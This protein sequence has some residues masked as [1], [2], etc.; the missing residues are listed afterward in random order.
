MTS[1]A[2]RFVKDSEFTAFVNTRVNEFLVKNKNHHIP[3]GQD[4]SSFDHQLATEALQ[5]HRFVSK[6]E[7]PSEDESLTRATESVQS[8]L[9]Y[10]SSGLTSFNP[11]ADKS[12]CGFSRHI[13]YNARKTLNEAIANYS[14]S[15]SHLE[16]TSGETYVSAR[17]DT[18][19]YAKLRDAK[20][21]T[22]TRSCFDLASR[23]I[24]NSPMLRH[25]A[26]V[27]YKS[28]F[29]KVFDSLNT[30]LTRKQAWIEWNN[31]LKLKVVG[32]QSGL[33]GKESYHVFREKL[34]KVVTI[35]PGAR[36]TTVP[37]NNSTDRVIECECWLNMLV[38]RTI[39]GSLRKIIKDF[40]G[41]D[42]ERS[43]DLH[44]MLISDL[45]NVTI[46]LKNASNSNWLCVV[47]WM[48]DR[49]L[50]L[51]H[52]K[53]SRC[54]LVSYNDEWNRLNMLSPNGNGYTFEVM[55]L[56]LLCVAR[57]LDSFSFVYGDDIIIDSDV[58]QCYIDVVQKMGYVLN[59]SK[60]F[61]SGS[62]RESCGAFF[63]EG[64]ITSYDLHYAND[65]VDA[66]ILTNKIG[67][68]GKTTDSLLSKQ[69]LMLH[70]ELLDVCPRNLLRGVDFNLINWST[71]K[72]MVPDLA[73][74]ILCTKSYIRSA[75]SKDPV[76]IKEH[77]NLLIDHMD[78]M[79]DLNYKPHQLSFYRYVSKRSKTYA[80][81]Y[82][83]FE[84][85][86][87]VNRTLGWFYV[88]SGRAKAPPLRAT[89]LHSEYR[90]SVT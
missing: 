84:S 57:E 22:V 64:Y 88:W 21:W 10:D 49:T 76:W 39:S 70:R 4:Y 53:Q 77:R 2:I 86:I 15:V 32:H 75:R 60:T 14:F 79:C 78:L 45:S 29:N 46:D 48:L 72:V 51:S 27:H 58:A 33:N 89:Y 11:G 9:K 1:S 30:T 63:C 69:W 81:M 35:V 85:K 82:D 28:Y 25:A 36:L 24:Y 44:G 40:Y 26:K 42:L 31:H 66:I 80:D 19:V 13:I 71:L 20:Q 17:G 38:Q 74:G 23:L 3:L 54:G 5:L 34:R 52:L 18:S 41:V 16:L 62:F 47:E 6:F 37:K 8:M 56:M 67:I 61:L 12:L 59:T 50:L 68:M 87:K 55:T 7:I 43:Q 65:I 83:D 73:D 90:I